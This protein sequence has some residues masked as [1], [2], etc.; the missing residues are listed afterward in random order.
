MSPCC[1]IRSGVGGLA[2]LITAAGYPL[3]PCAKG[4]HPSW[5]VTGRVLGEP[6][7]RLLGGLVGREDR[8]GIRVRSSAGVREGTRHSNRAQPAARRDERGV[9]VRGPV[10]DPAPYRQPCACGGAQPLTISAKSERPT[11]AFDAANLI[12]TSTSNAE[13]SGPRSPKPAP[14]WALGREAAS[15][16]ASTRDRIWLIQ[17]VHRSR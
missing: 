2:S 3:L 10:R 6:G 13:R 17:A 7:Q 1:S 9:G 4:S 15:R 16:P 8:I 14:R 5:A 11:P 12:S